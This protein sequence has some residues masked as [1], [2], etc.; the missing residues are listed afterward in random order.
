MLGHSARSLHE[1]TSALGKGTLLRTK[2]SHSLPAA[3]S[4]Q[5]QLVVLF[6]AWASVKPC[7]GSGSSIGGASGKRMSLHPERNAAKRLRAGA[8]DP[9]CRSSNSGSSVYFLLCG[10]RR[11]TLPLSAS[12]SSQRGRW[13]SQQ[14]LPIALWEDEMRKR[15]GVP[16][17][18]C[19]GR[20]G[21]V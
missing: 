18:Q 2:H 6:A 9:H 3:C 1:Y 4:C 19:L 7:A 10:L 14:C 15:W 5:G 20:G 16:C 17:T 21:S 8:L 11:L 12:V 13:G